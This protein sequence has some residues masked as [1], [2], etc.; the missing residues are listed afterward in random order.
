MKIVLLFFTLLISNASL[1]KES[2][3]LLCDDGGMALNV[4]EH[5]SGTEDVKTE[6]T[7]LFGNLV[8]TGEQKKDLVLQGKTGSFKG[9]VVLTNKD[10]NAAVNGKLFFGK[11][12]YPV[13]AL[14]KCKS[15][16]SSI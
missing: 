6:L 15:M 14:L 13:N 2:Y 8:F 4:Y 9:N 16:E 12:S 10:T 1:A 7:L 3:W 5:R 11:E